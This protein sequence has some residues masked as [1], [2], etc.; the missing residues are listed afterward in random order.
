MLLMM[1]MNATVCLAIAL[2]VALG[3]TVFDSYGDKIRNA[4][5]KNFDS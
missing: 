3:F 5:F 2:G 1:T 4:I